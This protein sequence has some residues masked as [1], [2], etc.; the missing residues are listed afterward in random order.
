MPSN[1][2][3]IQNI[4]NALTWKC[5]STSIR[6]L[7]LILSTSAKNRSENETRKKLFEEVVQKLEMRWIEIEDPST[8]AGLFYFVENFTD[9]F[10]ARLEDKLTNKAEQLSSE[11][12]IAVNF[13][14]SNTPKS[15]ESSK[16][17]Y[18]SLINGH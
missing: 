13:K 1:A 14:S 5:R 7:Y 11:E 12:I 9:L 15:S 2:F 3:L 18:S 17:S 8:I 6:N 10:I 4:E 16:S